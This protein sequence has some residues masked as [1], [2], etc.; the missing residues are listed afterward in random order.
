MI[1]VVEHLVLGAALP[2][3]QVF[4]T[5]LHF[6]CH[7]EDTAVATLAN[8]IFQFQGEIAE[9]VGKDEVTT[10]LGLSF[11]RAR[12]LE[13]D[14]TVCALPACRYIGLA[15]ATPSL[16][17]GAVVKHI[18]A[19]LILGILGE[20][21]LGILYNFILGHG[22]FS[23]SRRVLFVLAVLTAAAVT[24]ALLLVAGSQ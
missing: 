16:Q 22:C 1:L 8:L 10:A 2:Y 24:L 9:L 11:A 23:L 3:G 13:V 7:V 20:V 14:S 21:H 5:R 15:I 17:R 19:V 4:A 12:P 18:I 6:L